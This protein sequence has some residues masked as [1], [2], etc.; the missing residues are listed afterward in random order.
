MSVLTAHSEFAAQENK[1]CH[2]FH[3]SPSICHEVMGL[4]AMILVFLML[5]FKPAFSLLF[6]TFIKGLFSCSS[7]SAIKVD[8]YAYLRYLFLPVIYI[9]ACYSSSP[10]FCMMYSAQKL[11]KQGDIIQPFFFFPSFKPVCCSMSGSN[12]CF[13]IYTQFS[14]QTCKVVQYSYILKNSPQLLVIHIVKSFGIVNEAKVDIF[15]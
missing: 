1:I 3:F 15:L 9:P 8:S 11:N 7:L 5:S 14:Q 6:F 13:F 10:P 4:N 2:C 12:H